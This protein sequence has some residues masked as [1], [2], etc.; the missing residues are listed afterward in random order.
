MHS[1]AF[2]LAGE[3][4]LNTFRLL[5]QCKDFVTIYM[6]SV[7]YWPQYNGKLVSFVYVIFSLFSM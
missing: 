4:G 1:V 2:L 3:R 7:F 5:T 6:W